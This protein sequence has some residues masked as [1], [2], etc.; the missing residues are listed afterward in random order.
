MKKH[1]RENTVGPWAAEKLKALEDY[2]KFYC[3][4]LKKQNFR[5]VYV[6]AFAGSPRSKV[7]SDAASSEASP[8]LEEDGSAISQE[9]FLFGSPIRALDI[10]NGFDEHYFFD[11]DESRIET[12]RLLRQDYPKKIHVEI[13]DSNDLVSRLAQDALTTRRVRGVAF[14]DPYGAHVEWRTLEALATTRNMEVVINF[15][16][17]MAINRLIVRSG[18][19]PRNWKMQLDL[20]FGG[21]EW[22]QVAYE[23][24]VDL[25]GEEMVS[26]RRGVAD[27]LL[28][29]Y[30]RKLKGLFPCVAT[31]RLIRNSHN[32]PLYYLIWAGPH[33]LGLKGADYILRQGE[34][35]H[36]GK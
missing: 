34:V 18:N 1:H 23:R 16:V 19:V 22:H 9:E 32:S 7:R 14:L 36:V 24:T 4:A 30:I 20:C 2:L 27:D 35:V 12:L 13:G 17:A 31:P 29:L 8:F 15:P 10:A 28:A 3:T 11:L 26:K 21:D 33:K 5:L 6:D 25:F